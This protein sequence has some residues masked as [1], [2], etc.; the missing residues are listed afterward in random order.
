MLLK[1]MDA[2]FVVASEG[3]HPEIFCSVF[4]PQGRGWFFSVWNKCSLSTTE[5]GNREYEMHLLHVWSAGL[6]MLSK[7]FLTPREDNL[8][9]LFRRTES[10]NQMPTI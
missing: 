9:E 1:A 6:R 2:R 8:L 7:H 10:A 5:G 3:K 4:S